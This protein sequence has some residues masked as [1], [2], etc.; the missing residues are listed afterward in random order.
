MR[1]IHI[2][3]VSAALLLGALCACGNVASPASP[4]QSI[5]ASS[6]DVSTQENAPATVDAAQVSPHK[7]LMF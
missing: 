5:P 1:R 7:H 2:L 6:P 3:A 4:P